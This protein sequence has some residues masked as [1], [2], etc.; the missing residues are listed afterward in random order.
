[1]SGLFANGNNSAKIEP[2]L[3]LYGPP[4]RFYSTQS[5][6]TEFAVRLKRKPS[7]AEIHTLSYYNLSDTER[8]K[9]LKRLMSGD[10]IYTDYEYDPCIEFINDV[11]KSKKNEISYITVKRSIGCQTLFIADDLES[12]KTQTATQTPTPA[13]K[14]VTNNEQELRAEFRAKNKNANKQ[15]AVL[16]GPH[17]EFQSCPEEWKSAKTTPVLKLNDISLYS[18]FDKFLE[19]NKNSHKPQYLNPNELRKQ[20]SK[21]TCELTSVVKNSTDVSSKAM[22]KNLKPEKFSIQI[23]IPSRIQNLDD[24]INLSKRDEALMR[25]QEEINVKPTGKYK[26]NQSEGPSSGHTL[27]SVGTSTNSDYQRKHSSGIETY[28]EEELFESNPRNFQLDNS[29]FFKPATIL[30]DRHRA[31]SVSKSEALSPRFQTSSTLSL[32][33]PNP[34]KR[35]FNFDK[36]TLATSIDVEDGTLIDVDFDSYNNLSS[37]SSA[38]IDDSKETKREQNISQESDEEV[39]D[40][41]FSVYDEDNSFYKYENR[42]KKVSFI[43]LNN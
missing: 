8:N 32:S 22:G 27:S 29:N 13:K 40:V 31:S 20:L 2:D 7:L 34:Q 26:R 42:S 30:I 9:H 15:K 38:F 39:I 41:D 24:R 36:E 5:S 6:Q 28:N 21:S 19:K 35:F 12:N 43:Y 10:A 18:V 16:T 14:I 37:A 33:K 17:I 1:M 25:V 23:N 11:R 3:P 4:I